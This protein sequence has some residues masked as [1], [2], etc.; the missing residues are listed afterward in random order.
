MGCA[1]TD[2]LPWLAPCCADCAASR[3]AGATGDS[4]APS[5]MPT[6]ASV[7]PVLVVGAIFVAT[8]YGESILKKF[9][10]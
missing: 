9:G 4:P 3:A 5:P 8:L 1:T 2:A 6:A 7:V 10:G